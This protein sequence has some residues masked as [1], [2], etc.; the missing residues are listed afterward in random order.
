ML[1]AR[2]ER[3]LME[4]C[5]RFGVI[6]GQHSIKG[7]GLRDGSGDETL[8]YSIHVELQDLHSRPGQSSSVQSRSNVIYDNN[9]T[10]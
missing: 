2:V 5:I 8:V 4:S 7:E 3:K 9:S 10:I 6:I 1:A